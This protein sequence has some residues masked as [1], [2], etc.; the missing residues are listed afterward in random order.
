[1]NHNEAHDDDDNDDE[2]EDF[3]DIRCYKLLSIIM[4]LRLKLS[5]EFL[6][7]SFLRFV[8]LLSLSISTLST[9]NIF[10][11]KP[12]LATVVICSCN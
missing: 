11:L 9:L 3:D 8:I 10:P 5:L 2:K 7:V 4:L 12:T 6:S 1:M